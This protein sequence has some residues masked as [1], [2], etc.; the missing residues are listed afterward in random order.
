MTERKEHAIGTWNSYPRLA[1]I[2]LLGQGNF[3]RGCVRYWKAQLILLVVYLLLSGWAC[4][5]ALLN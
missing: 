5:C 2:L 3:F 1:I 4:I